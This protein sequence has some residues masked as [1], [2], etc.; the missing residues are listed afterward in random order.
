MKNIYELRSEEKGKFREEFNKLKFTKDVNLVRGSALFISIFGALILG[1]LTG[2]GE[3]NINV[4]KYINMCEYILTLAVII[5]IITE[6]Y[7]N[8]TFMRWMKIKHNIEY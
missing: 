5:F 1:I 8:I 7:L 4:E 6:V 2:L 3:E